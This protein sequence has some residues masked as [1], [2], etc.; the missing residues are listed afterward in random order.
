MN[1][2]WIHRTTA[3]AL[4][5]AAAATLAVAAAAAQGREPAPPAAAPPPQATAP[6]PQPEPVLAPVLAPVPAADLSP[7]EPAVA[8]QLAGV[9]ATAEA[10]VA[11]PA[12]GAAERAD[13][14]GTLGRVYHAYGLIEPA[15]AAYANAAALAP[16]DYRWPYYLGLLHQERGDLAAAAAAYDRVLAAVP[17]ALPALVHRGE[18][19]LDLDRPDEAESYLLRALDTEPAS[20]AARAVLGQVAL[21]RRDFRRAAELL[22]AALEALPEAT[23]LHYPLALAY[24]GLGDEERAREHLALRGEVGARPPDPLL[25]EVEELRVG[26]R[27]FIARGGTAYRFGRYAEA[28]EAFRAALAANPESVPAHIDLAAALVA[29]GDAAGAVAELRRALELEPRNPTARYNLALL[30]GAA[31]DPAAAARE[32]AAAV[33]SSPRDPG[34]RLAYAQALAAAGRTDEALAAFRVALDQN[35]T[36]GPA[37]LG[38]AQMLVR[39]GRYA[40]AA[41]RLREAI[42]TAPEDAE[43]AYAL[44][45]LLAAA[46]D[47]AARD[48]ATAIDLATQLDASLPGVRSAE[49]LA[50]ALA[51]AGRCAEAAAAQRR[52]AAAAR[53]AGDPGRAAGLEAAAAGYDAGPPCRPPLAGAPSG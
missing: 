13:A 15:L 29:L 41:G 4:T 19:A 10:V 16:G 3:A 46:P 52:A 20:A 14:Y 28:A 30:L 36:S 25:A 11:D 40:D 47:P 43:I 49:V 24:R 7:L 38:E 39:L 2:S 12:R 48:G 1:S 22:E 33:E 42:E 53:Q 6:A 51:E 23:R 50:L 8:E 26:E 27:V 37:R 5:A 18:V 44:A 34:I 32:L 45:K 35:P 21:S 17:R 9:R 31:G